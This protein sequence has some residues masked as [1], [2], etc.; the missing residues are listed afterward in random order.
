MTQNTVPQMRQWYRTHYDTKTFGKNPNGRCLEI[1]RTARNI[2]A[3][4]PSAVSAQEAT[5]AEFRI[6]KIREIK[7]G[8]VLYY[9]DPRDSNPYGHIVTCVGLDKKAD[10]DSLA[11]KLVRSNSVKSGL[12]T[13]VRGDYFN[14]HWGDPFIFA[15]NYLN[16][17]ELVMP[18]KPKP[19]PAL[20]EGRERRLRHVVDMLTDMI[21][22]TTTEAQTE[23]NEKRK[24]RLVRLGRALTR[25]RAEV[26]ETIKRFEARRG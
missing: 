2:D 14:P 6:H 25:D 8:H 24:A 3:M 21:N 4:W 26:L 18:S 20:G 11:S 1:C 23:T 13:V 17:E 9:D 22:K 15:S 19:P 7:P 10:P 5:P 12:I 16:G